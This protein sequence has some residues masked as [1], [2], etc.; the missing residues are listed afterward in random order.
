MRGSALTPGKD[1][2]NREVRPTHFPHSLA[3]AFLLSPNSPNP[4]FL[5]PLSCV[6]VDVDVAALKQRAARSDTSLSVSSVSFVRS[7]L[8]PFRF[9]HLVRKDYRTYLQQHTLP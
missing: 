8:V 6:A 2:T 7:G 1:P 3:R 4:S 9:P 5:L